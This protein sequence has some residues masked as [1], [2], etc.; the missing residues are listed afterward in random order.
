LDRPIDLIVP[1]RNVAVAIIFFLKLGKKFAAIFFFFK[2]RQVGRHPSPYPKKK[3]KKSNKS[4]R[5]SK[6]KRVKTGNKKRGDGHCFVVRFFIFNENNNNNKKDVKLFCGKVER[7]NSV[8]PGKRR[9]NRFIGT[10]T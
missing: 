8:K 10:G 5:S 6:E 7:N 2:R 1:D 3:N 9:P 4:P